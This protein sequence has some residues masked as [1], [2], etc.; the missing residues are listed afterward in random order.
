MI[1]HDVVNMGCDWSMGGVPLKSINDQADKSP[2]MA[3]C[4]DFF[5]YF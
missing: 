2:S 5:I 3:Q 4:T 1:S